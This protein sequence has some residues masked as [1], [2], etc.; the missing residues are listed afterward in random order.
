MDRGVY[1]AS[2]HVS[3][4]QSE[5][6]KRIA[7]G[8]WG[9]REGTQGYLGFC[10]LYQLHCYSTTVQC[11]VISERTILAN[12]QPVSTSQA[13]HLIYFNTPL[14]FPESVILAL[15]QPMIAWSDGHTAMVGIVRSCM[16]QN[17]SFTTLQ[18]S[19]T[20][21]TRYTNPPHLQ[22]QSVIEVQLIKS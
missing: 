18:G 8:D 5:V 17:C 1:E 6:R 22:L 10:L 20:L 7:D 16:I 13:M 2:R 11:H 12:K 14:F 3:S 21:L 9:G 15:G 19:T 4:L